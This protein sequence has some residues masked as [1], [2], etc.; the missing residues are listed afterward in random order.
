MTTFNQKQ[1]AEWTAAWSSRDSEKI[2]SFWLEDGIYKDVPL[3]LVKT[4]RK[5]IAA[6]VRDFF[7]G[8]ADLKAEMECMFVSTDHICEEWTIA[9]I[10]KGFYP[11]LPTG[12]F[13]SIRG[14]SITQFNG[15]L[16]SRRT[17]YY[18]LANV[19]RQVGAIPS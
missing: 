14:V 4:G 13:I 3:N 7:S 10:H 11:E 9:G 12:V 8:F 2:A 1:I 5:E 6:F 17:D 18:D 15:E 19:L 16:I